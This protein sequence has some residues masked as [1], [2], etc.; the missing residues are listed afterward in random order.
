MEESLAAGGRLL[1][2]C[3]QGVSRSASI[4]IAY[5][6]WRDGKEYEETFRRVKATRGIANPNMVRKRSEGPLSRAVVMCASV[7]LQTGAEGAGACGSTAV[8]RARVKQRSRGALYHH[9]SFN[10]RKGPFLSC[11]G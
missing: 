1:V 8:A 10:N 2:H 7:S 9:S 11:P 5:L 6:M 4:V 3:S